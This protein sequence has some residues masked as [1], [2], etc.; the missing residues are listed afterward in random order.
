MATMRNKMRY[1]IK[2]SQ[3]DNSNDES[4]RKLQLIVEISTI[5]R[6]Q[7][8][9]NFVNRDEHKFLL[10]LSQWVRSELQNFF[11]SGFKAPFRGER[12]QKFFQL[13]TFFRLHSQKYRKNNRLNFFYI[14]G[15]KISPFPSGSTTEVKVAHWEKFENK[16]SIWGVLNWW[17]LI[18]IIKIDTKY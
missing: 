10:I 11:R 4:I 12:I 5:N 9:V 18:F 14:L 17:Q 1:H 2:F 6:W 15:G 8:N 13:M 16:F 3:V 7:I